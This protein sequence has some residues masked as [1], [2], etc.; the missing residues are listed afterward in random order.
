MFMTAIVGCS[1]D[2][3]LV[4]TADSDA[5]ANSNNTSNTDSETAA[6]AVHAGIRRYCGLG[7]CGPATVCLSSADPVILLRRATSESLSPSL[8]SA[9]SSTSLM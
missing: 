2:D 5:R 9:I 3:C 8:S 1:A 4:V 7:L 6:K